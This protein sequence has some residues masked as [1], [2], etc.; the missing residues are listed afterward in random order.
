MD[1]LGARCCTC[2]ASTWFNSFILKRWPSRK[3]LDL[4]GVV[5]LGLVLELL[6][7]GPRVGFYWFLS[8]LSNSVYLLTCSRFCHLPLTVFRNFQELLCI[9]FVL[10][11]E[12]CYLFLA[13]FLQVPDLLLLTVVQLTA[14]T[15]FWLLSKLKI[16]D[17]DVWGV[18][19]IWLC[20]SNLVYGLKYNR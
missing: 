16:S 17:P 11:R 10:E 3:Q 9:V 4:F 19:I 13:C 1:L 15:V 12:F 8:V 2:A 14:Q 7:A 5:F 18:F 20:K 6:C